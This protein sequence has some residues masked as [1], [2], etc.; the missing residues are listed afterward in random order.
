VFPVQKV[1]QEF[2]QVRHLFVAES[3]R[4]YRSLGTANQD[5]RFGPIEYPAGRFSEDRFLYKNYTVMLGQTREQMLGTLIDE[6]PTQ[7]GKRKN[8]WAQGYPS[9][10][11]CIG[12]LVPYPFR[13]RF[14]V[15][16]NAANLPLCL[17]KQG[18]G[19]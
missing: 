13:G 18:R 17:R 11:A 10:T 1:A 2:P 14:D 12:Q 15:R 5:V 9:F 19:K 4:V 6:I 16:S 3:G 7:V 8:N